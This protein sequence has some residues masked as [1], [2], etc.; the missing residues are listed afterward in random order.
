MTC[1]VYWL[2]SSLLIDLIAIISLKTAPTDIE[3][4]K[5]EID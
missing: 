1:L 5:E 3:L 4:W 2:V